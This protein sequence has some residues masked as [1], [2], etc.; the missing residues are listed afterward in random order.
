MFVE[1]G[2]GGT[3]LYSFKDTAVHEPL[4]CHPLQ[5]IGQRCLVQSL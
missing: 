3:L 2:V 1:K 4:D 5:R